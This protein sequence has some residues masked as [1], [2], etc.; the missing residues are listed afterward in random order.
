MIMN[1]DC[2]EH[3]KSMKF[4]TTAV[5]LKV[6]KTPLKK[7]PRPKVQKCNMAQ[8]QIIRPFFVLK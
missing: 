1:Y 8:T 4:T 6:M 2:P 5:C 7:Y 3:V